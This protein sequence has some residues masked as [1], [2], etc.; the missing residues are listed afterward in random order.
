[1]IRKL[2][3]QGEGAVQ[4]CYEAGPTGEVVGR[5]LEEAEIDCQVIA[6]RRAR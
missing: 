2:E 1:M 4:C 3:R 6:P 5:Q